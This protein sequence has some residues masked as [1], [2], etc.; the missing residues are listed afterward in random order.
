MYLRSKLNFLRYSN[1][2]VRMWMFQSSEKMKW[3]YWMWE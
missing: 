3:Y 2:F 1:Y